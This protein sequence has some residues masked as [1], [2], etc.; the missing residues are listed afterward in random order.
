M[1]P[2]FLS[3]TEQQEREIPII[4]RSLNDGAHIQD[5]MQLQNLELKVLGKKS[6]NKIPFV[7]DPFVLAGCNMGAVG[8]HGASM[9]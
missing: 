8:T 7:N 9:I 3:K 6:M 2:S 1:E 4:I 5:V